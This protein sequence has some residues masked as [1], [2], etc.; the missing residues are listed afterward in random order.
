M[1]PLGNGTLSSS[2]YGA[3]S[4]PSSSSSSSSSE[5]AAGLPVS[6]N[7]PGKQ[8]PQKKRY[9]DRSAPAAFAQ[10]FFGVQKLSSVNLIEHWNHVEVAHLLI[11]CGI[12]SEVVNRF[13]ENRV[14]GLTLFSL[15]ANFQEGFGEWK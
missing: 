3:S 13:L 9:T 2:S 8:K 11:S 6:D 5:L 4:Y 7:D 12:K 15:A 10:N 1:E 14:T